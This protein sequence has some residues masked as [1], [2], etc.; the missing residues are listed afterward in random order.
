MSAE[1]KLEYVRP[2]WYGMHLKSELIRPPHTLQ[3]LL[4][5]ILTYYRLGIVIKWCFMMF[6]SC[7][8]AFSS[9]RIESW[10]KTT[11]NCFQKGQIFNIYNKT[12][13]FCKK[14]KLLWFQ[15]RD[16]Y[17]SNLLLFKKTPDLAFSDI[18]LQHIQRWASSSKKQKSCSEKDPGFRIFYNYGSFLLHFSFFARFWFPYSILDSHIVVDSQRKIVY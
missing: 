15:N 13:F 18:G 1:H 9:L 3:K 17:L 6:L 11:E 8:H 16:I 4:R 10:S 7:L 5:Y 12:L 14:C 2:N